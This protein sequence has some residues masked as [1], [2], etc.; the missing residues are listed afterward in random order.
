MGRLSLALFQSGFLVAIYASV[1][2]PT[3]EPARG[4]FPACT[5]ALFAV[6]CARP[7]AAY[8]AVGRYGAGGGAAQEGGAW[9]LQRQQHYLATVISSAHSRA[10]AYPEMPENPTGPRPDP[11]GG[12]CLSSSLQ[13]S[14]SGRSHCCSSSRTPSARRR[15]SCENFQ[16]FQ[17]LVSRSRAGGRGC[18][19]NCA[20]AGAR[21]PRA[22]ASRPARTAPAC[23][24]SWLRALRNPTSP[25]C[26]A[27]PAS[28]FT[29]SLARFPSRLSFQ[30][31]DTPP[32][33][34]AGG[35][36]Y[37]STATFFCQLKSLTLQPSPASFFFT[38]ELP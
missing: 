8:A 36:F 38:K 19:S 16:A 28:S 33:R 37:F 17:L 30:F 20:R 35:N 31:F 10:H 14:R 5:A 23:S 15:R 11:G 6:G 2:P 7:D 24:S 22:A 18:G 12:R 34:P 3:D 29:P 1:T 32:A 13:S 21:A 27:S 4:D 25:A 26:S 9:L